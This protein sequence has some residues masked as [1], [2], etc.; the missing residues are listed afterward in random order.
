MDKTRSTNRPSD[1]QE[2]IPPSKVKSEKKRRI[3]KESISDSE[4]D[5]ENEIIVTR[6]KKISVEKK[7]EFEYPE[8]FSDTKP[9][10]ILSKSDYHQFILE[11]KKFSEIQF[12]TEPIYNA[13]MRCIRDVF[14]FHDDY[15]M[16]NKNS[17][18]KTH[19]S[20]TNALRNS[21]NTNQYTTEEEIVER[22]EAEE[23]FTYLQNEESY[24]KLKGDRQDTELE[25]ILSN[26]PEL[27]AL[28]AKIDPL[29]GVFRDPHT[30][31][32][33]DLVRIDRNYFVLCFPGTGAGKMSAI[34]WKSNIDQIRN[35]KT[36]PPAYT[37]AVE[38]AAA[39]KELFASQNKKFE[40]AGHS[41]GGGIANYVGLKLNINSTCFNPAALGPAV[42]N[43]L[44]IND[45]LSDECIKKQILLRIRKDP[46]S[47][48][49]SQEFFARFAQSTFLNN[50]F[51]PRPVGILYIADR[52]DYHQNNRPPE[53]DIFDRHQ[54]DAFQKYYD[55][56]ISSNENN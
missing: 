42:L 14:K 13:M 20:I 51:I 16:A 4:S 11:T 43:D 41:L 37:Q 28:S 38:L 6:K 49:D 44:F 31:L 21:I 22:E 52:N 36:I 7:T 39:L 2:K 40:L 45:C 54:L 53:L 24:K 19:R 15:E 1:I 30:G 35:K 23:K 48:K 55:T 50:P 5:K 3:E 33:A 27:S 8:E 29:S 9:I 12:I 56:S 46:V 18:M 17:E 10:L 47:S 25:E 26:N 34:Q 32:Y